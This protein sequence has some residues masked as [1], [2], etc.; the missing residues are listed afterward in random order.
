MILVSPNIESLNINRPE[1]ASKR[2]FFKLNSKKIQVF[3]ILKINV[4][5]IMILKV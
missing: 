1:L 3:A 2:M 4:Y 5:I